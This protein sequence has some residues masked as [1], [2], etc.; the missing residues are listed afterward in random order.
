MSNVP[1][2]SF[3][4]A[5]EISNL[6]MVKY[7]I[8]TTL[9][10]SLSLGFDIGYLGN[11]YTRFQGSTPLRVLMYVLLLTCFFVNYSGGGFGIPPSSNS[12]LFKQDM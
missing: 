7:L 1:P 10:R 12:L 3:E 11:G 2:A 8:P 5:A 4:S 9:V 6:K